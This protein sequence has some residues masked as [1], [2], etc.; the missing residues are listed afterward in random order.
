M[1]E[2]G[3]RTFSYL[4]LYIMSRIQFEN[5]NFYHVFNR[6]TEKRRIFQDNS[7]Y[8]R[9]IHY[10][11]EFNDKNNISNVIRRVGKE[12]YIQ[13]DVRGPTSN[14]NKH[15]D[16]LVDVVCFCLMPNHYHLLL[17]QKVDGGISK[18]MQKLGTGHTMYFN[19]RYERNG[20]LF[21]GKFKAVHV[22]TDEQLTHLSR[23][24]HLN[25]VELKEP[26]WKEKGIK[27][28][29]DVFRFLENYRWSS[30]PDYI[31]KKNFPS[32]INKKFLDQY[33]DDPRDYEKFVKDLLTDPEVIGDITIDN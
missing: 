26:N 2:V 6:G 12:K 18:F 29:S 11:F 13:E 10:L 20:V 19:E 22:E 9:F 7:D 3:P 32:V 31:G 23:Y 16:L 24:I 27:N 30:Y 33:F 25:P 5:N 17:R 4:H 14:I 15:R 28:K 8:V 21:Q 1:F